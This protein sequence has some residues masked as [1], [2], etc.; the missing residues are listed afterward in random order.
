LPYFKRRQQL[1][2]L[3][4]LVEDKAAS[5]Q[6]LL[7]RL[8]QLLG[9]LP[10]KTMCLERPSPELLEYL[11]TLQESYSELVQTRQ[12]LQQAKR[13]LEDKGNTYRE[14][15]R[16]VDVPVQG[17]PSVHEQM[18][19][20]AIS[21]AARRVEQARA[22][23]KELE[24]LTGQLER[25]RAEEE[26]LKAE[27]AGIRTRQEEQQKRRALLE[28]ARRLRSR[29]GSQ[30]S[31]LPQVEQCVRQVLKA[32]GM[33]QLDE[34][35]RQLQN[36]AS[37][38]E[39]KITKAG[40]RLEH[41]QEPWAFVD[42]PIQRFLLFG[43]EVADDF[44]FQSVIMFRQ[45]KEEVALQVQLPLHVVESFRRWWIAERIQPTLCLNPDLLSIEITLPSAPVAAAQSQYLTL[46]VRSGQDPTLAERHKLRLYQKPGGGLE[47]EE[48]HEPTP[49]AASSY[50]VSLYDGDVKL[51]DWEVVALRGDVVCVAF[52]YDSGALLQG[53]SLPRCRI[54]LVVPAEY[55][56][57]PQECVFERAENLSGCWAEYS[58]FCLDLSTCET[59]KLVGPTG[60]VELPLEVRTST[61]VELRNGA[62]V[63]GVSIAQLPVYRGTPP[64]LR[65]PLRE[66]DE[67]REWR[68]SLQVPGVN[69]RW[70][71]SELIDVGAACS[72]GC[73]EGL[74]VF[75]S[76][77]VL[78][79]ERSCGQCVIELLK[80]PLY[81]RSVQFFCSPGLEV[82]FP[83]P[84]YYLP[85]K[86][87]SPVPFEAVLRCPGLPGCCEPMH[88]CLR[89]DTLYV[90]AG[91]PCMQL[92]A[93]L[94]CSKRAFA[95]QQMPVA[96]EVPVVRWAIQGRAEGVEWHHTREE[97]WLGDWERLP[98]LTLVVQLPT[99]LAPEGSLARL[100]IEGGQAQQAVPVR[101]NC[102]RFKLLSFVDE[103]RSGEAVRTLM[104]S[105]RS[106]QGSIE[107]FPLLEVRT[108]WEVIRFECHLA[109]LGER[110]SV[111]MSWQEVGK[112]TGKQKIIRLMSTESR[113]RCIRE[114]T[115][116]EE[117]RS[118]EWRLLAG[119]LPVGH[120][121]VLFLLEDSWGASSIGGEF[122]LESRQD[123][124]SLVAVEDESG[125]VTD[126][127]AGE[128]QIRIVGRVVRARL[129]KHEGWYEGELML[130]HSTAALA[131][132]QKV[133]QLN[134]V[135]F[136]YD[137]DAGII[138]ALE[139]KDGDGAVFCISCGRL[140]WDSADIK[141]HGRWGH[142]LFGPLEKIRVSRLE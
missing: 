71:L 89:A 8:E 135:R 33:A 141:Q 14:L 18:L 104:L 69:R 10:L 62:R 97:L 123:L 54:Q 27:L 37:E 87:G 81:R 105:T 7:R 126:L 57:H 100:D 21:A 34:N 122:S 94:P 25:L 16:Q 67:A 9:P 98:E 132:I 40:E 15:M 64:E 50:Q 118:V 115:L 41:C 56:V 112:A 5:R 13:E 95:G 17:T 3:E 11:Q 111:R 88:M 4:K 32:G 31:D 48:F 82:Q 84:G 93:E 42:K 30:Y 49:F 44:M 51:H 80:P 60:Q 101:N 24:G 20:E 76:H 12:E 36:Q 46:E 86:P 130:N 26:C 72:D 38:L 23:R 52:D 110:V 1:Q 47:S 19:A 127:R 22:A 2:R 83:P 45:A 107:R 125:E 66:M 116:A 74:C 91:E 129:R 58:L 63:S 131:E 109:S 39:G 102:A 140:L 124:L 106:L 114:Q 77:E 128:Y 113:P 139:D 138:T 142:R 117:A 108:R 73:A 134:P 6:R 85:I 65:I 61:E 103:L 120:Y 53:D 55:D 79:G 136:G 75:L 99:I 121:R 28:E 96:V 68:L 90:E 35:L 133:N 29:L 119:E 59:L 43:G 78:L 137:V 92:C 70:R